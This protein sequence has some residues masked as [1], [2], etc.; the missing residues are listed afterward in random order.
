MSLKTSDFASFKEEGDYEEILEDL[1]FSRK[2]QVSKVF[3]R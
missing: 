3:R 1:S 2:P